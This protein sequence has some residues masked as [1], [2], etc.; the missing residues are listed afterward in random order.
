MGELGQ[1]GQH[2]E[3][4]SKQSLEEYTVHTKRFVLWESIP[5]PLTW[6]FAHPIRRFL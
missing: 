5:L 6:Y 1:I 3:T 4:H 2:P